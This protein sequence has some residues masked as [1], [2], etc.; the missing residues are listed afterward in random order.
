MLLIMSTKATPIKIPFTNRTELPLPLVSFLKKKR[1]ITVGSKRIIPD[2][3]LLLYSYV[4]KIT[5]PTKEPIIFPR[6]L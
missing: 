3:I 1:S 6:H 2:N 5:H 4:F